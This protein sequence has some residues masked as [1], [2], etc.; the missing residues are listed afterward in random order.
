MKHATRCALI[1]SHLKFC[2][3]E[4]LPNAM[5]I[6]KAIA[7]FFFFLRFV[8]LAVENTLHTVAGTYKPQ[9]LCLPVCGI[10]TS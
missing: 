8:N 3:P 7:F 1:S 2:L 5:A 4:F 9:S 10:V 6:A